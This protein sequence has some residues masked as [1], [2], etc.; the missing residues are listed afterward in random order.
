M[1]RLK[2]GDEGAFEIIYRKYSMRVFTYILR[3][4]KSQESAEDVL[5]EVFVKAWQ[6]HTTIDP[7]K[8]Y[9]SFLFT[10][11]K[12]TVY[13]FIRK[14][15][16]ETQIA[17]YIASQTSELYQHVEEH[18]YFSESKDAIQRAI[19]C[20][21]PRRKEVYIRCKIQGLSYQSV[22]EEFGCSVAVVNAHIVKATKAI[23]SHIG[24]TQQTILL[25][26]SLALIS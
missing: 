21:P 25:A 3:L 26:V 10:V 12:H 8:N 17:A 9:Q 13:N 4:V 6:S 20:L 23:K 7:A 22:A 5:Q 1:L 24:L 18:L 19:D 2:E 11:A 15:S 14:T 16:L